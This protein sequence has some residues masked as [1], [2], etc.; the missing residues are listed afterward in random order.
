MHSRGRVLVWGTLTAILGVCVAGAQPRV[1]AD[2]KL[3]QDFKARVDAYVR[4]R[5]SADDG[6]PPLRETTEPAEIKAAQVELQKRMI[7][8]RPDAKHGD[9]FSADIAMHFRRLLRPETRDAATKGAIA[10]DKPGDAPYKVMAPYPEAATLS[11]VPPNVLAALPML[12]KDIEY[13][14]LGRHLILRDARANLI[15][16]YIANVLS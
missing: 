13:R 14:F 10:D 8:A 4:I 3:L 9:I 11:T 2:A 1:N 7:A 16:D 15:V 12:P 5:G 6:A